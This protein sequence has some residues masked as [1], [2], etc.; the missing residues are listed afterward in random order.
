M[1][2]ISRQRTMRCLFSIRTPPLL[3]LFFIF[4]C[5]LSIDPPLACQSC[6]RY[7]SAALEEYD[8]R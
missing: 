4:A 8:D 5:I 1:A 7:T 3:F 2:A 6:H